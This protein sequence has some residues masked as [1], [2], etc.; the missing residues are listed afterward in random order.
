MAND[1]VKHLENCLKKTNKKEVVFGGRP[2]TAEDEA[3]FS[4]SIFGVIW[5]ANRRPF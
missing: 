4:E 1:S 3:R 2:W 5:P